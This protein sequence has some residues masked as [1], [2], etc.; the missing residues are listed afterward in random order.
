M[1]SYL[2]NS[3]LTWKIDNLCSE[4]TMPQ[5]HSSAHRHG[6]PSLCASD[7]SGEVTLSGCEFPS[8]Y[9]RRGFD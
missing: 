8:D 2:L 6:G 9:K 5:S 1:L 7:I 3:L 4:G